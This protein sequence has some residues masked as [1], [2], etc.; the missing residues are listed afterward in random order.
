VTQGR[1]H[2]RASG[3][4]TVAGTG[5]TGG[6]WTGE[7]AVRLLARGKIDIK[8]RIPWSSNATFLVGVKP[9][10]PAGRNAPGG[11]EVLAIYKPVRGERPLW[12][13]PRGLWRREVA[14]YELDR[15]LGL[16]LVPPT[17]ARRDGPLGPGSVQL[18]VDAVP[19]E[20]YFSLVESEAHH[21]ALRRVAA[22]DVVAN[23]A[24]R[25][26]GHCLLDRSGRIWAIDN[27]LCFHVEP[28]LRTVVWDFAGEEVAPELL[29]RIGPLAK[30][31][32][33]A[34]L[35][36]LLDDSEQAAL[37]A[38]AGDLRR[39]RRFPEPLS[40]YAYPWPLI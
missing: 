7:E 39:S 36:R 11:E 2:E 27:G 35:A 24:D 20:H 10:G 28:K 17:A 29:D 22:F 25:K 3:A 5:A 38:R 9:P 34:S 40:D 1:A 26:A 21:P 6:T 30:G 23:N 12:D 32:L 19:E 8:G 18:C 4:G 33:P 14:A 37:V 16:E 31:D 15:W 13:F